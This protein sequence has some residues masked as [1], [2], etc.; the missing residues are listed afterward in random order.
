MFVGFDINQMLMFDY[1]YKYK[2]YNNIVKKM[3]IKRDISLLLCSAGAHAS[4]V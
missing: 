3:K 2:Y 1:E 4:R